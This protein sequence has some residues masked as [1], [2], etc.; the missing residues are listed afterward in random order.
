MELTIFKT[1][2][3]KTT[4]GGIDLFTE[5]DLDGMAGSFSGCDVKDTAGQVIGKVN[6]IK[7]IKDRLIGSIT[8]LSEKGRELIENG[9]IQTRILFSEG[10]RRLFDL[11]IEGN[12][13]Y[14]QFYALPGE[15]GTFRKYTV[16]DF[17]PEGKGERVMK[18]NDLVEAKQRQYSREQGKVLS[19]SESLELLRTEDPESY[20]EAT[21]AE[22]AVNPAQVAVWDTLTTDEMEK[23]K[24]GNCPV[25]GAF[26]TVSKSGEGK[27]R[28]E[29]CKSEINQIPGYILDKGGAAQAGKSGAVKL[30]LADAAEE[31][32]VQGKFTSYSE[33]L[34]SLLDKDSPE[35]KAFLAQYQAP[36]PSYR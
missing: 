23:V 25:C 35:G 11:V 31:L 32:V 34:D 3:R 24:R 19:Y 7:R 5:A 8:A 12:G 21:E 36:E 17:T 6:S 22:Y 29:V 26:G 2:N 27:A 33:A 9:K 18:L 10:K 4:A 13:S 20:R 16:G 14:S 28:C 1:G 30:S 15:G